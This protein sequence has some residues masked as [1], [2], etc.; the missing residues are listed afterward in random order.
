MKERRIRPRF[1]LAGKLTVAV[2]ATIAVFFILITTA[3]TAFLYNKTYCMW[4][5]QAAGITALFADINAYHLENREYGEISYHISQLMLNKDILFVRITD[6]RGHTVSSCSPS[7]KID[8]PQGTLFSR[9]IVSRKGRVIG[10]VEIFFSRAKL[11]A[12][13]GHVI[14]IIF[15]M[16]FSFS[17]V[18]ILIIRKKISRIISEPLRSF[19]DS[20]RKLSRGNISTPIDIPAEDEIGLLAHEF[21]LMMSDLKRNQNLLIQTQKMETIGTLA[22]GIA[23]DFN[24][25]LGGIIGNISLLRYKLKTGTAAKAEIDEHLYS[26]ETISHKAAALSRQL[27]T[28]SQ[29]QQLSLESVDLCDIIGNVISICERSFGYAIN[30]CEKRCSGSAMTLGDPTQI[31]Q[32]VLNVCINAAH[33]M[34]IMRNKG[35]TQGG[36]L[37]LE[38]H[39]PAIPACDKYNVPCNIEIPYWGITITD[40]GVGMEAE[41]ITRI[42]DPF[43]TKKEA[44]Q[45]SGL[46]MT[47]VYTIVSRHAGFVT[48][49]SEQGKG[50]SVTLHFPLHQKD[51]SFNPIENTVFARSNDNSLILIADDEEYILSLARSILSFGG[52]QSIVARNG[53]EAVKL[54]IERQN[55]IKLVILDLVMPLK[56]G[57]EAYNEIRLVNPDIQIMFTSGLRNRGNASF[58]SIPEDTAFLAKPYTAEQLLRIVDRIVTRR[59]RSVG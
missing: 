10:S 8:K 33:A 37:C 55:D 40:E 49:D 52:Y 11:Y 9:K 15:F 30:I 34:T 28:F 43:F 47:M 6:S 35:E 51:E 42:F 29:R 32:A 1:S 7:N 23:H 50:T 3:I 57:M 20:A 41:E 25:I 22:S 2:S 38:L 58:A 24:N 45:G 27:L 31:E 53:I 5:D 16:M 4:T 36:K 44:G 59:A 18:V 19:L 46:G 48:I 26:V 17:A 12:G 21:N 14:A 39:G 13:I 56:N 54:F